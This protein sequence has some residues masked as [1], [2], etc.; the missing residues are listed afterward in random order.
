ML[1]TSDLLGDLKDEYGDNLTWCVSEMLAYGPKMYQLIF[2]DIDTRRVV[3]WV[4]TMKG[5][6]LRGT[7][8]MFLTNKIPLYR[9]PALDF[10]CILQYGSDQKYGSMAEIWEAMLRLKCARCAQ[11]SDLQSPMSVAI[12]FDQ[13]IFR[14]ELMYVFTDRFVMSQSLKKLVRV[15]QC[16]CFPKPDK[17]VPFGVAFP[18]GWIES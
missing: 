5:I 17:T 8:D 11:E 4:K 14:R 15:T 10:C 6:S 3:K 13:T 1:L 16:K 2:K 9:N 12:M 7:S 18:I